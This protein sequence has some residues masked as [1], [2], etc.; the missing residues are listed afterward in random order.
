MG[1]GIR[2]ELFT[3]PIR[4]VMPIGIE[5][6]DYSGSG[7]LPIAEN[8][9][10]RGKFKDVAFIFPNAPTIPITVVSTQQ[11]STTLAMLIGLFQNMGIKMPG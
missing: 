7:W 6:Y 10:Q 3:Q 9:R 8:F 11:K 1:W 5:A 2:K 4:G